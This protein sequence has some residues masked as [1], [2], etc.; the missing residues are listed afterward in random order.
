MNHS[1]FVCCCWTLLRWVSLQFPC[2]DGGSEAF[3][4]VGVEVNFDLLNVKQ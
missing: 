4:R 2:P 3:E 1:L